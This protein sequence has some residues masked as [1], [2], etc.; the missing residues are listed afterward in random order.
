VQ[1]S[2]RDESGTTDEIRT[3]PDQCVHSTEAVLPIVVA[4]VAVEGVVEQCPGGL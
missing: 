4:E 1:K 2:S 3:V